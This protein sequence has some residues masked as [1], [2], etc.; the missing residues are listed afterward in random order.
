M[1]LILRHAMAL[2]PTSGEAGHLPRA[3]GTAR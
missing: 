2:D 1:S 3:C